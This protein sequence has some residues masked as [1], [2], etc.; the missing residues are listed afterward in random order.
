MI[1]IERDSTMTK[2]PRTREG[3][4]AIAKMI[5][6]LF[7]LWKISTQEQLLLLGLSQTSQKSLMLYRTG[8]PLANKRD[9]MDRA[10]N[11]LAI[12]QS[13]RILFPKNGDIAYKWPTTPNRAFQGRTPI[14]LINS[15]GFVGLLIVRRYLDSEREQ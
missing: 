2:S 8:Y 7:D 10:A 14:E 12:H 4:S 6:N 9:I 11:L 3:R 13:L 5:M 15:Q 1:A